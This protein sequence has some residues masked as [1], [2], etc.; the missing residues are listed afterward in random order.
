[1]TVSSVGPTPEDGRRQA[2]TRTAMIDSLTEGG[3]GG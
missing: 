3:F 2:L 1:M